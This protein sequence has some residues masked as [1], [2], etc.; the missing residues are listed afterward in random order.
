[1]PQLTSSMLSGVHVKQA[2]KKKQATA[3]INAFHRT[4][5]SLEQHWE[6]LK[7]EAKNNNHYIKC[8]TENGKRLKIVVCIVIQNQ[9]EKQLQSRLKT[10]HLLVSSD[11]L[12]S[13]WLPTHSGLPSISVQTTIELS[14]LVL[15]YP[16]THW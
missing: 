11:L 6:H 13:I 15:V 10:K 1:M 7:L 16:V 12:H 14:V 3:V 8:K 2:T 5:N 9:A 4:K